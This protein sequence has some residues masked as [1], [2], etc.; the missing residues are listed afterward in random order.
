[1][2]VSYFPATYYIVRPT[3]FSDGSFAAIISR[4]PASVAIGVF[5]IET[6]VVDKPFVLIVREFVVDNY[7]VTGPYPGYDEVF[8]AYYDSTEPVFKKTHVFVYPKRVWHDIN[9]SGQVSIYAVDRYTQTWEAERENQGG[10][11]YAP[12]NVFKTKREWYRSDSNQPWQ[13]LYYDDAYDSYT[14]SLKVY[15]DY[16]VDAQN[17]DMQI[18]VPSGYSTK[19]LR[20][21]KPTTPPTQQLENPPMPYLEWISENRVNEY[22]YW[23]NVVSDFSGYARYANKYPQLDQL[24]GQRPN[25]TNVTITLLTND[26]NFFTREIDSV[27][28]WAGTENRGRAELVEPLWTLSGANLPINTYATNTLST[29]IY[30]ALYVQKKPY[31]TAIPLLGQVRATTTVGSNTITLADYTIGAGGGVGVG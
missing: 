9:L 30:L 21:I 22:D 28:V 6:E 15:F 20:A 16:P 5:Q 11:V 14:T 3:V 13:V 24:I 8:T 2:A 18:N 1:M 27:G 23:W 26:I 7:Y 12:T 25:N 31:Q 10:F 4:K 19:L 17:L 29:N